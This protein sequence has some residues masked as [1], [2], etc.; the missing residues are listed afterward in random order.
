MA[1]SCT[2]FKQCLDGENDH[3]EHSL[4]VSHYKLNSWWQSLLVC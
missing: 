1:I 2:V 3:A 4:K